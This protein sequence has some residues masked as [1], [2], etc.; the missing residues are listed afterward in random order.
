V[1]RAVNAN[2]SVKSIQYEAHHHPIIELIHSQHK[3]AEQVDH[4]V[5][6]ADL[7]RI[8]MQVVMGGRAFRNYSALSNTAAL[9]KAGNFRGMVVSAKWNTLF[10][11]T[12]HIG[13]YVENIGYLTALAPGSQ[14][15]LPKL[16][17]F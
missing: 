9:N 6:Q 17:Q 14:N 13:E 10:R 4:R 5:G 3:A 2:D 8:A 11:H 16:K 1:T 7:G 12:S 15:P